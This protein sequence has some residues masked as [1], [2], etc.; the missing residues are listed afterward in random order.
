VNAI[1]GL[2]NEVID[3]VQ[4]DLSAVIDFTRTASDETAVVDGKDESPQQGLVLPIEGD[5]EKNA[6]FIP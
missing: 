2:G 3:L 1:F 5:V 4:P 6:V